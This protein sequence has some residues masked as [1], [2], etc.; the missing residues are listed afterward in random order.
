MFGQ[1]APTRPQGSIRR[2]K[3]SFSFARQSLLVCW[4]DDS[5]SADSIRTIP[6]AKEEA[7]E[8]IEPSKQ[9]AAERQKICSPRR[10][11]WAQSQTQIK[12]PGGRN[13]NNS[14]VLL[15]LST[16]KLRRWCSAPLGFVLLTCLL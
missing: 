15:R 5:K 7:H 3:G 10:E 16:P 8:V 11:P 2:Q 12:S 6:G 4:A 14:N 9:T 1:T 13:L